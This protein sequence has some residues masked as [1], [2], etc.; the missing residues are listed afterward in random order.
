[1]SSSKPK[2]ESVVDF[3][4]KWL[5][6]IF[7]TGAV[8]CLLSIVFVVLYQILARYAL[9]KAPVWTE[10][11]SRYFFIYSIILTSGTV[12]IK[13]RHVRLEIFQH[14]LSEKWKLIYNIFCHVLISVFC[15]M[16]IQYAWKY[17]SIGKFQTSPALTIKM[18]WIFGSTV[19]FFAL[20]PLT[21]IL[22]TVKDFLVFSKKDRE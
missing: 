7:N 16:L 4:L 17:A 11:I 18:S 10:E 3:L 13:R 21:C 15:L 14:K 2:T 1:M 5:Q 8:L 22:L 19:I 6:Y 9:P 12:I 20:V